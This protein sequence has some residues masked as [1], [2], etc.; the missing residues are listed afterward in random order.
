MHWPKVRPAGAV[1]AHGEGGA[2]VQDGAGRRGARADHQVCVGSRQAGHH[3][4]CG[5][6]NSLFLVDKSMG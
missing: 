6:M 5:E 4:V 1:H 3:Q 2:E